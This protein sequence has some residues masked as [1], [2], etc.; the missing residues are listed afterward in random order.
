MERNSEVEEIL[1]SIQED[2]NRKILERYLTGGRRTLDQLNE[3][4]YQELNDFVAFEDRMLE[5]FK[6]NEEFTKEELKEQLD[7][8]EIDIDFLLGYTE[9]RDKVYNLLIDEVNSLYERINNAITNLEEPYLIECEQQCKDVIEILNGKVS[10]KMDYK[11]RLKE[12][13]ENDVIYSEYKSGK[14][15]MR[16]FDKFC[17]EHCKD[18][19]CL[20][21]ENEEQKEAI[22]KA[23]ELLGNYKHYSTP[24]EKQ[25]SDNEDLVNKAFDIL[26]EVE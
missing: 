10:E 5:K 16:D 13:I 1:K 18:I 6:N 20:L 22:D 26:K 2:R 15:D 23:I 7:N 11:E 9:A 25:N 21:N 24:D 14:C 3:K 17:I 19:E 12:Y 8:K 4:N